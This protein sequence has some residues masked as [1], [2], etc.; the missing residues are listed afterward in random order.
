MTSADVTIASSPRLGA[1]TLL[2]DNQNVTLS[3]H[4]D[5][6]A[7]NITWH[8]SNQSEQ[9]DTIIVAATLTEVVYTCLVLDDD[10]GQY[11]GTANITILANGELLLVCPNYVCIQD[12][13]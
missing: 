3:C 1:G 6:S 9:G 7:A 2:C 13:M 4:T 10:D 5:H 12:I 8:W 11:I